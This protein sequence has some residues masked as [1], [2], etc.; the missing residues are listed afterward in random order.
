MNM[1]MKEQSR[2]ITTAPALRAGD[3][4][5][6][7][8]RRS[9]C[10]ILIMSLALGI[11]AYVSKNAKPQWRAVTQ[12]LLLQR[13]APLIT[14][15]AGYKAPVIEM[16]ET[17]VG[18]MQSH[19][20]ARRTI[21]K[22]KNEALKQGKSPDTIG[23]DVETLQKAT[24][25]SGSK[26]TNLI[27]ISV[28]AESREKAM[29]L[30]DAIATTFIE[31]KKEVTQQSVTES[32]TTLESRAKAARAKMIEAER[33]ETR[34]KQTH[35]I[36]DMDAEQSALLQQY[37]SRQNE[38]AAAKQELAQAGERLRA[39]GNRLQNVNETIRN[40]TGV[41]DDQ[42]VIDLQRQ[43]N[44]LEIERAK[45]ALKYTPEFPG[46]LPNLDSQITT[47][48]GRLAEKVQ[49]TLDEK[50]PSLQS[51]GALFE[52]Y[53][54]AQTV[55]LFTTARFN[56]IVQLRDQLAKQLAGLPQTNMIYARLARNAEL[57]R[58]LNNQ[59]QSALNASQLDKDVSGNNVQVTQSA[60]APELPFRPNRI[61]DLAFGGIIGLF[62]SLI[63]V[64][65]L[66]QSDRRIRNLDALRG[67]VTAP[68]I[69]ALPAMSRR[70]IRRMISGEVLPET[71]EAT[72]LA[73]AN[74]ALVLQQEDKTV[75]GECQVMLITSALPGEGKSVSASQLARSLAY[76]GK[77]V[78]LIDA[79]MRRP[80]QNLLFNTDERYGLAEVL[81]GT[82]KLDEVLVASDTEN[83]LLLH[84][85]TPLRNPTSLITQPALREILDQLRTEADV[86]IVDTP[87]CSVVADALLL[88]PFADCI[89][90]VV[91]L[92]QVDSDIV[93]DAADALY[94]SDPEKLV[95]FVNRVPKE[96][97]YGYK[98]RYYY[99]SSPAPGKEIEPYR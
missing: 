72:L 60:F 74:L 51:Q 93:C 32:L 22:L 16:M 35:K 55:V 77:R 21:N 15:S 18:L 48:K 1:T 23:I 65:L 95:Y 78:V 56:A 81:A 43:L 58:S 40:G 41:R 86:I 3:L 98:R 67:L 7:L 14:S 96:K 54:E 76:M 8:W 94:A 49:N 75:P 53:K 84:S 91:G 12:I 66:E 50:K 20:M 92:G 61:R 30:A 82:M 73:S 4:V 26:E 71:A 88:A 52:E 25:I 69:G 36:V 47:I 10:I 27:E 97:R 89:I 85:G 37:A 38:V 33:Q 79:D 31:W 28:D 6:I 44:Q 63:S 46:I 24:T 17:Q 64:L 11:S 59:L 2:A 87:A 99:A 83:L 80:Q 42:E 90:H 39:L 13:A 29:A 68:I 34:F 62:L 5:R 9:W 19:T 70:D 57:A 45:A